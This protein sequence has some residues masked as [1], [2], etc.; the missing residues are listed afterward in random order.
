MTCRR[1]NRFRLA[2]VFSILLFSVSAI[3]TKAQGILARKV[4][5]SFKDKSIEDV[6]KYLQNFQGVAFS[7]SRNLVNLGQ[8]VSGNFK[9][10]E[11]KKV[12]D[13][14][15][16]HSDVQ[17][18]YK[19]GMVILHP[20]P[21][22]SS[23]IVIHG[24]IRAEDNGQFV[25]FAGVQLWNSNKG[26]ITDEKGKFTLLIE[27]E[28]LND[29]LFVSS[30]G[31]FKKG[32]KVSELKNNLINTIYLKRRIINLKELK[33]KA[34]DYKFVKLGNKRKISFGSIYIDTQGQQ[35]A[36]FIENKKN[37]KGIIN[38]VSYYLSK[39]GNTNSTF[40][41]RIYEKDKNSM[42]PGKDILNEVL[43]AKPDTKGGWYK[44]DLSQFHVVAP[45]E[46]FFVA[47]EGIYPYDYLQE[48]AGFDDSDETYIP[49]SISYGQRL[50][51]SKKSGKNT[52]HYS[53]AHTWFQLKD[54]NYNVMIGAEIQVRKRNK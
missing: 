20:K 54:N 48:D 33:I 29:S 15:F 8:K 6:V 26:T 50:G 3:N 44:I 11:I 30:L 7:Y 4:T 47:I 22:I 41:V 36:L 10:Q 24:V 34:S 2:I 31:Y 37:K 52:W 53:L 38:S 21:V 46:G 39:K 51:Y 18:S 40:R 17:Y 28:Q 14:I 23:K 1:L 5:L 32:L 27:K 45:A 16:A 13:E 35:T 12:L 43:I 49:N 42:Q 9:D 25:E 19:A